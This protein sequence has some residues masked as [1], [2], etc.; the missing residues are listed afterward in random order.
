MLPP[1]EGQRWSMATKTDI[2]ELE[3]FFR[4]HYNGV[5]YEKEYLQWIFSR[6]GFTALCLR[7]SS[8]GY[9]SGTLF[10]ELFNLPKFPIGCTYLLSMLCL[11]PYIRSVQATENKPAKKNAYSKLLLIRLY[12]MLRERHNSEIVFILSSMVELPSTSQ[13]EGL[14]NI[15][16]NLVKPVACCMAKKSHHDG[17]VSIDAMISHRI[18]GG[19]RDK[20]HERLLRKLYDSPRPPFIR[21]F[22]QLQSTSG[23]VQALNSREGL[24]RIYDEESAKSLLPVK[25]VVNTWIHKENGIITDLISYYIIAFNVGKDSG[26]HLELTYKAFLLELL[27]SKY[28]E[29]QLFMLARHT[30]QI[31]KCLSFGAIGYDELCQKY[32][33]D[34]LPMPLHYYVLGDVSHCNHMLIDIDNKILLPKFVNVLEPKFIIQG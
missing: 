28:T 6:P 30:S 34:T 2:N 15:D 13:Y 1:P 18:I 17:F 9:I 5:Y 20:G 31:D 11:A 19:F 10:A 21:E 4:E 3:I 25:G 12:E 29:E 23:V 22:V 14:A 7:D 33:M 27:T 8:T 26:D 24:Y 16:A 32:K